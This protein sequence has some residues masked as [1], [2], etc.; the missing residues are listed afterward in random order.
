MTIRPLRARDHTTK[1]Q[2][3]DLRRHIWAVGERYSQDSLSTQPSAIA[4]GYSPEVEGRSL[5]L[6]ILYTSKQGSEVYELEMNWITH[7]WKF[8]ILISK[9]NTHAHQGQGQ[10]AILPIYDSYKQH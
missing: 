2:I 3:P 9:S 10:L 7:P 5:W 1:T 8:V 6:K 4:L